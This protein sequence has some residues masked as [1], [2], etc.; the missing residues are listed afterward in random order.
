[1]VYQ[2]HKS[3]SF[4]VRRGISHGSVLDPVLFSLFINDLPASLCLVSSAALFTLTIWP[5]GPPPPRPPLRRRPLNE[6]CFDWNA[7]LSTNVFLSIRANVRPPS[8]QW[9]PTELTPLTQLPS[10][11]QP[12]SNLSWAHLR[13]H[14]FLL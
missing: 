5:F 11:F 7:G 13:P 14:S 3:R 10:P 6:L 4:R 8:T 12:N 9:I 1:M 2:N